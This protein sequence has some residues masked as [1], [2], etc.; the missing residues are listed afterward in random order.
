MNLL[1][2]FV[3]KLYYDLYK[4]NSRVRLVFSNFCI[5]LETAL[6]R[7]NIEKGGGYMSGFSGEREQNKG[8]VIALIELTKDG[9]AKILEGDS[10]ALF[11][12]LWNE[13]IGLLALRGGSDEPISWTSLKRVRVE[14]KNK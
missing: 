13:L 2:P 11:L 3:D 6:N 4:K 14:R 12:E 7:V 10:L 5:I 9:K 1:L 8:Q